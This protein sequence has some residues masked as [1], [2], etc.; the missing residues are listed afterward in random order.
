MDTHSETNNV[1]TDSPADDR[2]GF[3]SCKVKGAQQHKCAASDCQKLCHLMCYQGLLLVKMN[4]Q[5]LAAGMIACTKKCYIKAQK[6]LSG[7]GED[8]EGGR[9]GKWDSDGK[10]GPDDPNTSIRILLDWWTTE[11]NYSKFCGYQ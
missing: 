10:N 2:C 8:L 6:E 1:S 4:L 11:G 3:R 9:F 5:P 7:G